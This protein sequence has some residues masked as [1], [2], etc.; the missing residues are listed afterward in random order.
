M[1]RPQKCRRVCALPESCRFGPMDRQAAGDVAMTVDEYEV[2][3]LIDAMGLT[4]QACSE[5]M[6]V[7]RTTVQAIY[8]SARRKIADCLTGGKA[9]RIQGGSY[10]LCPHRRGCCGRVCPRQGRACATQEDGD[11]H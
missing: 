10:Q 8:D 5:R 9:L 1:P 2:I 3:R 4:Q 6:Q 7:A 11:A